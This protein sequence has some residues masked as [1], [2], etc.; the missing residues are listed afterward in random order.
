ML[1]TLGVEAYPQITENIPVR[2]AQFHKGYV[3]VNPAG[4]RNNNLF[5]LEAGNMSNL[6]PFTNVRTFYVNANHAFKV[7]DTIDQT[8]KHSVGISFYSNKRGDYIGISRVYLNYTNTIALSKKW[9]LTAGGSI[10][11]ISLNIE[12]TS[13]NAGVTANTPD[14]SIGLW[15][16][17]KRTD[18]ALSCNQ[19]TNSAINP[20][21]QPIR[22][23]RYFVLLAGRKYRIGRTLLYNPVTVMRVAAGGL[24]DKTFHTVGYKRIE[25]DLNNIL[26]WNDLISTGLNFRYQRGISIYAG[27]ERIPGTDYNLKL[28]MGYNSAWSFGKGSQVRS[29]EIILNYLLP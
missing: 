16:S 7:I 18:I 2:F 23:S 12:A 15:A 11:M 22:F 27:I 10:G 28:S 13:A 29:F 4:Q 6:Y 20:F 21:G 3:L 19:F 17:S 14:A 1:F 26:I 24:N 9:K 25:W 5:T 8:R